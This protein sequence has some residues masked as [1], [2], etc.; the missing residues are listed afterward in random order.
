MFSQDKKKAN[1]SFLTDFTLLSF[2]NSGICMK[3]KE[4]RNEFATQL[5]V[6][7]VNFVTKPNLGQFNATKIKERRFTGDPKSAMRRTKQP[8]QVGG[9]RR[10]GET[11]KSPT[12][13]NYWAVS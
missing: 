9:V 8:F 1:D 7:Q 13:S 2:Q 6:T 3:T 10:H 4:N 5:N 12:Q 11:I